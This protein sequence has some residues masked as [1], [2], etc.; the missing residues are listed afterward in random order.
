LNGNVIDSEGAS[1]QDGA[2]LDAWPQKLTGNDNQLWE[3]T[4]DPA[5]S[6]YVVLQSSL[7]GNVIDIQGASTQ[8]GALLDAWPLK[9]TGNDNQLWEFIPDP[10][11]SG[12]YFIQSKLNG[13]VID[14]QGASIQAGAALDAWPQ[15]PSGNDNQLW[16]LVVSPPAAVQPS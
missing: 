11:G 12:Y 13:N 9:P 5:G 7:N 15:K 1:T 3:V 10:A 2:L 14:I 8:A 6:G 16:I 4:L